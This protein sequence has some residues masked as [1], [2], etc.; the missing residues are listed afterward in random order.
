MTTPAAYISY[1]WGD[2]SPEGKEREAIVNDL[3][4][5][6]AEV[7]IVIGKDKNE[8]EMG[9]S[10]EAFANRI[11]NA[12]VILA[13]ISR[14]SLRSKWCMIYE[15]YAAFMRRGFNSKEFGDDVVAL[16]LDDALD[17]LDEFKMKPLLTEWR[18]RCS[19][20]EESLN[21]V[22]CDERNKSHDFQRLVE[23]CKDMLATLPDM[24]LAINRIA[25]PRGNEAIRSNNFGEIIAYVQSKLGSAI[26]EIPRPPDLDLAPF[27][28]TL[29]QLA[30][31]HAAL[32]PA[33]VHDCWH[34]AIQA[35]WPLQAAASLFPRLAGRAPLQWAD[36]CRSIEDPAQWNHHDAA[37]IALLFE[38]FSMRLEK[39]EGGASAEGV[40][41][42]SPSLAV[43]I[44]PTGDKASSGHAAYRCSAVLRIPLADGR[45][46]YQQVEATADHVFCSGV[47]AAHANWQPPG[48]VLGRLWQAAKTRLHD[49]GRIAHEPL[50]DLFLPRDLLDEDWSGL[51]LEDGIEELGSMA[52]VFYRLRSLDRWT[53]P[54]LVLHKQHFDRKHR[55]IA[56]GDGHWKLFTEDYP[57]EDLYKQLPLSRM[58]SSDQP[59]TVAILHLGSLAMDLR[60]RIKFYRSVLESSAPVVLWWHPSLQQRSPKDRQQQ[61][62]QL[63]QSLR[64]QKPTKTKNLNQPVQDNLLE[65]PTRKQSL[66]ASLVVLI[67]DC[68]DMDPEKPGSPRLVT[69]ADQAPSL[70]YSTG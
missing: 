10:I 69:M 65:L 40:S 36:L 15:L 32:S 39:V 41:P 23:N 2:S 24:L 3:C 12:Q 21:I 51:E 34:G 45:W 17:D 25:M 62:L 50:L 6:F 20:L 8:V 43:L 27:Q 28:A 31:Q 54:E 48:V 37:R 4:S 29:E 53:R 13:V 64:I 11:A 9:D 67:E 60:S 7:N 61:K 44:R 47:P 30:R 19:E 5:R 38:H 42:M 57:T 55:A 33:Q 68:L 14:Q 70:G 18:N 59:E 26:D 16:V 35:A 49:L 63:Y 1:S 66:P 52:T 22:Q 56:D 46:E 58:P